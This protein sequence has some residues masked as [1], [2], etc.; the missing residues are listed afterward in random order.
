MEVLNRGWTQQS[1][2]D[3]GGLFCRSNV[4]YGK[5]S[6]DAKSADSS[7]NLPHFICCQRPRAITSIGNAHKH[8]SFPSDKAPRAHLERVLRV[9]QAV[10]S[11]VVLHG[12]AG[13]GPENGQ[14][15]ALDGGGTQRLAHEAVRAQRLCQDVAGLLVHLDIARRGEILLSDHHHILDRKDG[16]VS[17][18]A[19]TAD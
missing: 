8:I 14:L 1:Q 7:S 11:D 6:T 16:E 10:D 9:V 17:R 4:F 13:D 18:G 2:R 15:E 12:G 3:E 5:S 19:F